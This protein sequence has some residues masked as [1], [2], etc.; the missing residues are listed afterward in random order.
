MSGMDGAVRMYVDV[1]RHPARQLRFQHPIERSRSVLSDV[2]SRS[3]T[4]VIGNDDAGTIL[5]EHV[6]GS[7]IEQVAVLPKDISFR[8]LTNDGRLRHHEYVV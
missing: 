3:N 1:H 8:P 7:A 5:G 4:A 2:E 6:D